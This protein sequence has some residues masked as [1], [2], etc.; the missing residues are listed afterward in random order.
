VALPSGGALHV[1]G[2]QRARPFLLLHGVGGGA[3]SWAP[4]AAALARTHRVFVWEARGHGAAR[5]VRDAGLGDY[6]RDAREAL[7]VVAQGGP[8]WIGGHSM[9]GL[10]ALALSADRPG[11][12]A[13]L[14]LVDPVYAPEGGAHGGPLLARSARTLLAPF[15][16]SMRRDG[17]VARAVAR[18]VF[19]ASFVDRACME[20]AW[21]AQRTQVPVEY[22]KMMYEA[23][24]GPTNFDNRAFAREIAVP[25]LLLEPL[26]APRPRFP[27][28]V[29]E[30]FRL[31]E[32][33]GYLAVDGGHYLQL[34]RS[35]ARVSDAIGEF[36]ARWSR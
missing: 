33:F 26:A 36:A 25:T 30:L 4:Q 13:G 8:A 7:D 15:V 35:A 9:G 20:R 21:R 6:Y 22:P 2:P 29:R 14:A 1:S 27:Q 34:D 12:V 31:G 11:G 10:L 24:E 32:R 17:V 19:A 18:R 5:A 3:W 28:L 16:A 23:F